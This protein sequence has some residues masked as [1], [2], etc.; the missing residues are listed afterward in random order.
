MSIEIL[1]GKRLARNPSYGL[2]ASKLGIAMV[3][4][5]SYQQVE[6]W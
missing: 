1:K 4:G 5:N 6:N 2:R 3:H